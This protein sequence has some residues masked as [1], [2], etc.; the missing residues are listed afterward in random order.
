MMDR[1]FLTMFPLFLLA[2]ILTGCSML[3]ALTPAQAAQGA[4]AQMLENQ[5]LL[6]QGSFPAPG[7]RNMVVFSYVPQGED[8]ETLTALGFTLFERDRFGLWREVDRGTYITDAISLKGE[9]IQCEIAAEPELYAGVFGRILDNNVDAIMAVLDDGSEQPVQIKKNSFAVFAQDGAY[10][11]S[12]RVLDKHGVELE[13]LPLSLMESM[14]METLS[15]FFSY[16]HDGLYEK[17]G[18]LYGGSYQQLSEMNSLIDPADHAALW[19]N[20]CK[21]NGF[22]CL[23]ISS[24]APGQLVGAGEFTFAVEFQDDQG[25]IFRRG[26]CCGA[27]TDDTL[28]ESTFIYRVKKAEDG[29]FKVLDLPPYLP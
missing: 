27:E 28:G 8:G 17:A 25:N 21:V 12:L 7:G 19:E 20:A 18:Q 13:I 16:L 22:Q 1:R 4:L 24:I 9:L 14:A 26:E 23:Y 29:Q 11:V 6:V 2:G 15:A 5:S 3:R 10:P